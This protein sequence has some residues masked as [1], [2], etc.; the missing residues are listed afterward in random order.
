MDVRIL[1]PLEVSDAGGAVELGLRQARTLFATLALHAG[2]PISSAHLAEVLWPAGPPAKWGVTVQSHVSRLRRALEPDRPPRS[3]SSRLS[4]RGDAYVLHLDDDEL[5]ARRF[6]LLASQ[7][8]AALAG[9]DNERADELL[10]QALDQWRGPVLADFKDPTLLGAEVSRLEEL[11]AL[12]AEERAEAALALGNHR[13]AVAD[14]EALVTAYPLRERCWE[15]LLLA[16]YR[17]GRQSE[18]LRR[19]QEVRTLLVSELG[20]EPGP[21]LCALEGSI[22]RQEADLAPRQVPST[23]VTPVD[24]A[25]PAWL[26]APDD[27]FVGRT[28]ELDALGESF[29]RTGGG[30][31]RLALVVGEPGIGKSRLVREVAQQLRSTGVLVLGGRCVQEPLHVLQPFAEALDRLVLAHRERLERDAPS[32]LAVLAALVPELSEHPALLPA[33]DAQAHRYALFRAISSLLDTD[34][35]SQPVVLV[36]DDLQWATPSSLQLLAHLLRDEDRGPLLVLGTTRDTE[37]N[38]E[39]LAL[40]AD[41]RR[42]RRVDRV[43]LEGLSP[44]EV[45]ALVAERGVDPTVSDFYALTEGN[46]FYVEELARHV[47]E[48]GGELDR[49]AVP[50]SVRDTIAR[51]LLRL[52]EEA[53]RLLGIAAVAGPE[54]H[55]EV[56][57]RAAE[58]ELDAA[59]D[60]LAMAVLAGVVYEHPGRVGAYGFSHALIQTALRDGLGAAR[61]A[62]VH[63]RFGNALAELGG[64]ESAVARHLLAAAADH[65]DIAPGVKAA[66]AAARNAVRRHTYDDAVAI[67]RTAHDAL[68]NHPETDKMMMCRVAL[69]LAGT[70]RQSGNYGGRGPLLEEAWALASDA[71]EAALLAEVVVESFAGT[72]NAADPW[73][74][75]AEAVRGQLDETSPSRVVLAAITSHAFAGEPGDRALQLAEWAL[76]RSTTLGPVDRRTVLEYCLA[77]I[78]ACSPVERV[79]D[80]ARSCLSAARETGDA[81]ELVQ[82][83]SV[84]RRAYLAAADPAASDEVA[85]EYEELVRV[86]HIPRYLA[87]VE[88]RRAMRALLSGRFT[89][90]EARARQAVTLEPTPE[91]MEGFAVQLFASRLEQG[92]LEEVRDG[93][94]A[95]A[96]GDSH[97]AWSI[98]HALLLAELDEPEG[99]A[100]VLHPFTRTGFENVPRDDLYF[101]ALCAA[102]T[103]VESLQDRE[104]AGV[105]YELLAPHASRVIVAGEG[106]VCWGAIH[107]FL[108]PLGAL[109]D[110]SERA[111]VHFEASMSLHERLGARP[112][113]ARDRLAYATLLSSLGGDPKRVEDLARSGLALATRLGMRSILARYESPTGTAAAAP[114]RSGTAESRLAR[115]IDPRT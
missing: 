4:T 78:G 111:S 17:S 93:V 32:E 68:A 12:T 99:A 87:G 95:W 96:G 102:A 114:T 81:F 104:A 48:S 39:L 25:L 27:A 47:A 66:L 100:T 46:P 52:P 72:V 65:S 16:L 49:G 83:L 33:V 9:D 55:L 8:R 41:L 101:L 56:V 53:R 58:V 28:G 6:E 54:F 37:P 36:L 51:R 26:H 44:A 64:A 98:G 2:S 43:K 74:S 40:V 113:L 31:R 88:Q 103:A 115:P 94:E 109:L 21:A 34:P 85:R 84:L 20:I 35:L 60:A 42:D 57:A 30:E 67:L 110:N 79:L 61:R 3:P 7:G 59:D 18:A 1:G 75:R 38:E 5:D 24:L 23:A 62:R 14:L 45:Q 19:F 73:P 50:D 11:R 69:A 63:R 13:R 89:E 91:F 15:L 70:L 106:A 86:V 108:G 90:A 77:A 112:F 82:A 80:L 22:L 71:G 76:A 29:R 10:G 97:P 105:L 107:R 92:R